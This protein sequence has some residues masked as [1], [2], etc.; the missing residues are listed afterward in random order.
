MHKDSMTGSGIEFELSLR[1]E[2]SAIPSFVDTLINLIRKCGGISV[3][4]EDIEIALHEALS[5]AVIHGNHEDP[6]K[7][8]SVRCRCGT[9]EV[10]IV[11]RDE[12]QGFD[13]DEVPDP[14]APENIQSTHGRGIYL[15]KNL[16]DE[17]RFEQGGTVVY[18][19]KS[20]RESRSRRRNGNEHNGTKRS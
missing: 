16:M 10:S 20:A 2:V 19:R 15:M 4:E 5:N 17:V 12:G 13:P 1:S 9:D 7:Q 6:C 18:L 8:I 11:I 3:N 14:T